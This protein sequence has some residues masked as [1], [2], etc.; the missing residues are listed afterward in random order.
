[1]M[2][3]LCVALAAG[4]FMAGCATADPTYRGPDQA[5]QNSAV[6]SVGQVA[7]DHSESQYNSW[8]SIT[9]VDGEPTGLTPAVRVTPGEH[10][11]TLRHIDPYATFY[12][13]VRYGSVTFKTD[14][15]GRYR[16]DG[17]FCCGFILGRLKLAVVDE[18]S[19]QQIARGD[20]TAQ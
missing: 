7:E 14:A 4:L 9:A 18:A 20:T 11:I 16:I 15:G 17:D 8:I 1:M 3:R 10:R 12:G 13:N 19:G 5:D 6:V 2:R